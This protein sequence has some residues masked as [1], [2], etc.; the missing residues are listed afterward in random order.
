MHNAL[1][2]S[3]PAPRDTTTTST[4]RPPPHPKATSNASLKAKFNLKGDCP[5][6]EGVFRYCQS[7]VGASL[8]GAVQINHGQAET[9]INWAG[10]LHHAKTNQVRGVW[11]VGLR[12]G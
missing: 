6:F 12:Q 5:V 7:Y 3:N 2:T 8:G 1:D 4:H 11:R 10:G 9:V